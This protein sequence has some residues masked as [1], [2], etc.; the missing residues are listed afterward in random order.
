MILVHARRRWKRGWG[1]DWRVEVVGKKSR[2]VQLAQYVICGFDQLRARLDEFMAAAA[3]RVVDRAWD[4][5]N[6]PAVGVRQARGDQGTA[7][8]ARFHYQGAQTQ[9]RND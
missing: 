5:E 6:V 2:K 1:P 3:Q 7:A 8:A 4:G 9:A